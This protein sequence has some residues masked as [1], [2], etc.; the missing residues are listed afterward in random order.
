M[1]LNYPLNLL[2]ASNVWY[3]FINRSKIATKKWVWA[4]SSILCSTVVS[5]MNTVGL[6]ST[7]TDHYCSSN[8]TLPLVKHTTPKASACSPSRNIEYR[9]STDNSHILHNNISLNLP[10]ILL[11]I[12]I[13]QDRSWCIFANTFMY[14][15]VVV[16]VFWVV[17]LPVARRILDPCGWVKK[18]DSGGT[19]PWWPPSKPSESPL[20]SLLASCIHCP[21]VMPLNALPASLLALIW[22]NMI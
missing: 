18:R 7:R 16:S 15:P 22:Q 3:V 10:R 19:Q 17:V 12:R 5:L 6:I 1:T 4:H 20:R 13:S 11:E 2:F 21:L 9:W 14:F 8:P